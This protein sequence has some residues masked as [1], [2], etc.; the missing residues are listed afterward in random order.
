MG[1]LNRRCPPHF[2]MTPSRVMLNLFQHLRKIRFRVGARNDRCLDVRWSF[3]QFI[4]HPL[5]AVC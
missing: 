3:G 5:D 2:E 1:F 4:Y